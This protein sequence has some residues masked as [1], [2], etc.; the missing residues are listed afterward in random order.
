MPARPGETP[1]PLNEDLI[2]RLETMSRLTKTI[3]L[4]EPE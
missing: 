2:K 1:P 3:N 4:P